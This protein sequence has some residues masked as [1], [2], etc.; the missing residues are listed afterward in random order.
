VPGVGVPPDIHPLGWWSLQ[1]VERPSIDRF[2]GGTAA[3]DDARE[4]MDVL[5]MKREDMSFSEIG[6]TLGYH[7]ATIAKW[8]KGR[9]SATGSDRGRRGPS[10]R[11]GVGWAADRV[12]DRQPG[13]V[14]EVVVRDRLGGGLRRLASTASSSP[15]SAW[16]RPWAAPAC[17]GTTRSRN[18]CG[19]RSNG[20]SCTATGSRTGP[21]PAG[22]SSPGSTPTTTG[23][24]TRAG[25][26]PVRR[27]GEPLPSTPGRPGRVTHVTG[28]RGEPQ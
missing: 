24:S 19:H 17:A 28:Q 20:R 26:R 16:S 13:P 9:R 18:R 25:S 12:V 3:H 8:V 10:G 21:P 27:V 5:A 22:R 11:S 4:F 7:P 6:E 15:I 2:A 14:G 1:S 23:G